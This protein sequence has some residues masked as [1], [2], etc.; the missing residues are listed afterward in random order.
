MKIELKPPFNNDFKAG[1]LLT[2]KEPRRLVL[3]VDNENKQTSVSYARYLYSCHIGRYLSK[4]EHVDHI[5]NNKLNDIIEN[6]QILTPAENNLKSQ[7]HFAKLISFIC[8]ICNNNFE[9]SKQ[10]AYNKK[11]PC[12]SRKC[13]GIKSHRNKQNKK[14]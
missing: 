12:C 6:L 11:E 3:L 14:L 8:P 9:L 2:N 13:G 1:Y 4:T 7:K 10:R 5:D